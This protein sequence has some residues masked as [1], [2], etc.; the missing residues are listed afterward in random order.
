MRLWL[1]IIALCSLVITTSAQVDVNCESSIGIIENGTEINLQN[2][3]PEGFYTITALG[4]ANFDP[5]MATFLDDVLDGCA[6]DDVFVSDYTATLPIGEIPASERNAQ[7]DFQTD[8][9]AQFVVGSFEDSTGEFVFVLEG[10]LLSNTQGATLSLPITSQLLDSGVPVTAFVFSQTENFR[11]AISLVDTEGNTLRDETDNPI[12]C[13]QA[14]NSDSCWGDSTSLTDATYTLFDG[15]PRN[16]G[17]FDASLSIPLDSA[18]LGDVINFRIHSANNTL[19]EYVLMLHIGKGDSQD[20]QSTA[21]IEEGREGLILN[22]DGEDVLEDG[23]LLDVAEVANPITISA[24][25]RSDFDPIM[26]A[27]VDETGQCIDNAPQASFDE[28]FL[29]TIETIASTANTQA[30]LT[31]AGRIIVGDVNNLGGDLALIINGMSIADDSSTA[32]I[33][34]QVNEGMITAGEFLTVYAISLDNDFDPF[35]AQ[36]DR[37]GEVQLDLDELPI[38]CDDAGDTETCWGDSETLSGY[39]FVLD[40]VA[41]PGFGLDAMLSIPLDDVSA[42]DTLHFQVSGNAET[43]GDFVWVL[44]IVT[45]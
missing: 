42:G 25:G 13:T 12:T 22:C 31:E 28:V 40:E 44:H 1:I 38:Q 41:V 24:L 23:I 6:D 34:L 9:S 19:G 43:I 30:T 27:F 32:S 16:G 39:S 2:L 37:V 33:S 11:P 45:N 18:F 20:T 29:P 15:E 3:D 4:I 35:L 17:E 7:W 21:T 14:G 10:G 8:N 5:I 26:G 36:V